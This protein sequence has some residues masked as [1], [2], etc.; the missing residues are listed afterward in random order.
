MKFQSDVYD[1]HVEI[2]REHENFVKDW[3]K[4]YAN[5][6]WQIHC[7]KKHKCWVYFKTEYYKNSFVKYYEK[8]KEMQ[9]A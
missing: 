8:F 4:K 2:Q 6:S 1:F 9:N 3:C 5:A 7:T